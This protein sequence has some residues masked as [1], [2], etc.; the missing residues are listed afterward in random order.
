MWAHFRTQHQLTCVFRQPLIESVER[1][2]CHSDHVELLPETRDS[3]KRRLKTPPSPPL[4]S[5]RDPFV[6]LEG[7]TAR[8][9]TSP[10]WFIQ[11]HECPLVYP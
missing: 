7:L 1:F 5:P 3:G 9:H 6:S 2:P 4:P 10:T 11:T 8:N